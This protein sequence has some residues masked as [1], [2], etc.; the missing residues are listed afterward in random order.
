MSSD[1]H[2]SSSRNHGIDL[3]AIRDILDQDSVDN[4]KEVKNT[5]VDWILRDSNIDRPLPTKEPVNTSTGTDNGKRGNTNDDN[6]TPVSPVLPHLLANISN[7]NE[8]NSNKTRPSM[9]PILE[10]SPSTARTLPISQDSSSSNKRRESVPNISSLGGFF[11][12]LKGKFGHKSHD[13]PTPSRSLMFKDNYS[14]GSRKSVSSGTEFDDSSTVSSK[15]NNNNSDNQS[16]DLRL[17]RSM[18]TPNYSN[19]AS[20]PRL[21]ESPA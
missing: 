11:S 2:Q 15:Y 3:E 18:S 14:L 12:K 20:D 16:D 1:N 4:L 17:S 13:E 5:D 9:A 19:P 7:T 6:Y 21:E 8:N 10:E